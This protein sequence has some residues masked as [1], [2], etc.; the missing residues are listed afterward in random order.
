MLA[1]DRKR[2]EQFFETFGLQLKVGIYN[3]WGVD[4]DKLQDLILYYSAKNDKFITFDEYVKAMPEGQKYIYY[5]AG[6]SIL[7]I[8]KTPQVQKVLASGYDVLCMTDNVDE[9]AIK[10]LGAYKEKEFKNASDGDAGIENK[11]EVV[12]DEDK[13]IVEFL[14]NTLAGEV[15]DVKLSKKLGEHPVC[16]LAEGEISIEMEKVLKSMPTNDTMTKDLKAKKILEINCEHK[17]YETIKKLYAENQEKL[18]EM[19]S[20]LLDEARL[21]AGLEIEDVAEFINKITSLI[22]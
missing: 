22:I 21:L 2:Y 20:V 7:S 14:K 6:N 12:S 16:L 4:K 5:S 13:P 11:D 8:K 17:I 19:A 1:N 18:K 10:Y 3:N 9:F 15:F